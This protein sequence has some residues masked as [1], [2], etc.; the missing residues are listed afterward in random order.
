M[1]ILAA[2]EDNEYANEV[3]RTA[4]DMARAYDD[5]LVALHVVPQGEF[6]GDRQGTSLASVDAEP[7]E[8]AEQ[9]A[10]EQAKAVVERAL[11]DSVEVTARG[12][13]DDPADGILAVADEIDARF[14]VV[15]ARRRSPVGKAVFGSTTQSVLL[16]ADQPVVTVMSE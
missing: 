10:A 15:G 13:I 14:V 5:E 11:D 9:E 2:V 1:A 6:L 7:I 12:R 8:Q 4:A 16:G 3:V